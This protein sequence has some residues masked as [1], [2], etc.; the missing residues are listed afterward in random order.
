MEDIIIAHKLTTAHGR[1]VL[2]SLLALGIATGCGSQADLPMENLGNT[3]DNLGGVTQNATGKAR[4]NGR[5]V[6]QARE[7]EIEI[8]GESVGYMFP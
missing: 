4:L 2:R 5:W 8:D 6:G 1:S 7:P 3:S